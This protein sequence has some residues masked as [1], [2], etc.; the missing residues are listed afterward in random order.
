MTGDNRPVHGIDR[1]IEGKIARRAE[2]AVRQN[3]LPVSRQF[4]AVLQHSGGET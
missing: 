2:R 1:V 3:H 4:H